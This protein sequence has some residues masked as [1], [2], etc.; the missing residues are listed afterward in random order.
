MR[1]YKITEYQLGKLE[2]ILET[3]D[4]EDNISNMLTEIIIQ[5]Q[6]QKIE[7]KKPKVKE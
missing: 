7:E 6:D 5:I 1:G 2:G 4:L 3:L